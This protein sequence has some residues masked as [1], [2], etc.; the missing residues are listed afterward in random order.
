MLEYRFCFH[1]NKTII[2]M[3]FSLRSN[4]PILKIL[5]LIFVLINLGA[6]KILQLLR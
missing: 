4:I 3:R 5:K 1:F 2:G 6:S